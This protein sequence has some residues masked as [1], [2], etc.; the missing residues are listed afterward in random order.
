MADEPYRIFVAGK[1]GQV[2]LALR[3]AAARRADIRLEA[4]GRPDLD[5]TIAENVRA[6]VAIFQ[7]DLIINAAAYTAVDAAESDEAA[8]FAVNAEGTEA[9][10]K[11]ACALDVPLLHLSTD[12]VFDGSKDT[13]YVEGDPTGPTGVYGRSKLRGEV[14]ALEANPKTA[15]FRTAWVYSPYGK[16]FLKTMLSLALK[17]PDLGVVADQV[18]NPTYAPDIA[19]ALIAV[20]DRI[21]ETGWQERY[22]G[23]FHLT[24]SGETSWHGFAEAIFDAGA[25]RGHPRP[26]VSA[27]TTADYPTPAARPANSRLNGD[28]LADTFGIRLPKWPDSTKECVK[29]LFESGELG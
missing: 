22:T 17:R 26:A 24:G 3:D 7:P 10:A 1:S 15:V 16:N 25:D 23:I 27:I 5:M 11:A 9:L 4:F 13:P 20:A 12:Y 19:D 14:L 8:A 28:K 18:G 2:A 6:A 29:Q 21:R